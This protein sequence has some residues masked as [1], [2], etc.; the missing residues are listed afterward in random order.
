M[1]FQSMQNVAG[2][3]SLAASK[4]A[5]A[6]ASV[7]NSRKEHSMQVSTMVATNAAVER[8][9]KEKDALEKKYFYWARKTA[10]ELRYYQETTEKQENKM[11]ELK[12]DSFEKSVEIGDLE[13][14]IRRMSDEV[15]N[16]EANKVVSEVVSN[17]EANKIVS[18]D[19]AREALVDTERST[20]AL[21]HDFLSQT[22]HKFA[23]FWTRF[24]GFTV[25]VSS[26]LSIVTDSSEKGGCFR[27]RGDTGEILLVLQKKV[28]IKSVGIST[29]D[30]SETPT[31]FSVY[32][33]KKSH[34][35]TFPLDA[36]SGLQKFPLLHTEGIRSIASEVLFRFRK[37]GENGMDGYNDATDGHPDALPKPTYTCIHRVH[38]YGDEIGD[39]IGEEGVSGGEVSGNEVPGEEVADVSGKN[40]V[41]AEILAGEHSLLGEELREEF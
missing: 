3:V 22:V 36:S 19:W 30:D 8:I 31:L 41:D 4:R 17:E 39:E 10:Y 14:D 11:E 27:F 38:V 15:Q 40:A 37:D 26:P 25:S 2:I 6:A 35:G 12:Q 24:R 21:G 28:L 32:V 9:Q 20:S 5:V 23:F 29:K 16:T 7:E 34:L 18:K 33:D 13:R 1:F